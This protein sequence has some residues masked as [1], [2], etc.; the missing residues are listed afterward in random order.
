MKLILNQGNKAACFPNFTYM[1]IYD[2]SSNFY[3]SVAAAIVQGE[4]VSETPSWL[5]D[6]MCVQGMEPPANASNGGPV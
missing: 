5:Q 4:N 3:F 1:C 2:F 6:V